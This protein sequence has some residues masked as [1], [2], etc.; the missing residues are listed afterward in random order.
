M[1]PAELEEVQKQTADYLDKGW[2]RPSSSEY[3][4]PVIFARKADGSLRFCVDYRALNEITVKDR[5]PLPRIDELLDQLNGAKFFTKLDLAQGYHQVQIKPEDIHKTAFKTRYGQFEFTVL[6]FG[7]TN[8]PASFMRLMNDTLG[9]HL[10][11]FVVVYLDDI[12]IFS[13]TEKDHLEHVAIVLTALAAKKLKIKISKCSFAQPSTTF[14]GYKVSNQGLSVD[15]TKVLAVADWPLPHDITSTRA[16]LG[17]TGFYRRFIEGYALISSPLSDLTRTLVPFPSVLPQAAVDSFNTLK[18]ALLSAPLLAIPETGA[19]AEFILFTDASI[20]GL[21]AVLLQDQGKGYQPV[22]YESRKTSPAERNY[23]IHELELLA[24]VHGCKKFRH[25][26]HGCKHFTLFTDHESLHYFFT[27]RDISKRQARWAQD[28][29]D[30]QP[31]MTIVYKKGSENQADALS[32]L[33][34][35]TLTTGTLSNQAAL[36]AIRVDLNDPLMQTIASAYSRDHYF[37][38]SQRPAHLEQRGEHWY[39]TDRLVVPNDPQIRARILYEYHDAPSAGHPGH[40]RTLNNVSTHFWWPGMTR[41]IKAYVS[42]CATCQRIKPSTQAQPGLL[43]PHAIPPRPWAHVSLDLITDLPRSTAYDGNSFDSIATFVCM[44]TKQAHFIRCNKTITAPHLTS[45]FLDQIYR[46]HGLP[47]IFVSDR[48]PRFTSSFWASIFR[49]LGTKLNMSTSHHPQTDGQT[50]RT[51][52]TIEQILR[53]YVH[54]LH[55]DWASWLPVAEFA[56][57]SQHHRS[58]RTS[59]FMANYGFQPLSPASFIVPNSASPEAADYLNHLKDIQTSIVFALEQSKAQ[60]AAGADIHRRDLVFKVGDQ[61]RLS[62][63]HLNLHTQPSKKLRDRYLGPFTVTEVVGPH[64]AYR[65]DL[66]ASMARV[67]PVFH[68]DRLLPWT[69]SDEEQFPD[70]PIPPQPIPAARDFIYGEAY[71]VDKILDVRIQIDDHLKVGNTSKGIFF[72]VRYSAPFSDPEHN[73]WQPYRTLKAL[74]VMNTYLTSPAYDIFKTTP[75]YK[76][77]ASRYPKKLP[78]P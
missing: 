28:L 30:F 3:G 55:D 48:D 56:Y 72:L 62:S 59:P 53:A 65:L 60:Q 69:S 31:N 78:R 52:R 39:F 42:S 13:K 58:I 75:D 11:K 36:S 15:S 25:Y 10:D 73:L 51:H 19:N 54:P 68:V 9:P 4:A 34:P 50:E 66:P 2:I 63:K 20:L 71:E 45:L 46:L 38:N 40:L 64:G 23:P 24:V 14:L 27:Q 44:L 21:G 67:H 43:Q 16:F 1:S 12:L 29:A 37:D 47:T 41:T 61:V 32:R 17:F 7:L 6:P 49:T 26:L 77:F 5:Y 22:C 57:N 18:T 35:T 8:A 76:Q 33:F 74:E 70:R